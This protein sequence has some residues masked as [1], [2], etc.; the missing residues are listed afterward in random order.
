MVR[1]WTVG[2]AVAVR[3]TTSLRGKWQTE[4]RSDTFVVVVLVIIADA[5]GVVA[6]AC[7]VLFFKVGSLTPKKQ[8]PKVIT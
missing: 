3:R 7:Y 5:V 1:S 6:A 8:P 2:V 4:A